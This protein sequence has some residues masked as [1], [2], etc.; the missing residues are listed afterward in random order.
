MEDM[1]TAIAVAPRQREVWFDVNSTRYMAILN[2]RVDQDGGEAL[3]RERHEAPMAA[4][5][6][7]ESLQLASKMVAL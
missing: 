7:N 6:S 3:C 1:F 5:T 2:A 4:V